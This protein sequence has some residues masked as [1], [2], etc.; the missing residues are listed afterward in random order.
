MAVPRVFISSTCYDL[1]EIRFQLRK[2]IQDIGYEPVMSEFGDI[3]Y[4]LGDHVQDACKEEINRSNIF[5]LVIGNNYGSTYHKHAGNKDIPD[6][7]TLQEFKKALEVGIPKYIFINRFVQ[8]DFENYKRTLSKHIAQYFSKNDV[9]DNQVENTKNNL[10][11]QYDTSYPFP[12]DAYKYVFYFLDIVYSLNV[13]NARYPFESFDDIK[14]VLRKQWAGFVYDALTKESTVPIEK[15]D[16]FGKKLEKIEHQLRLIAESTKVTGEHNKVTIDLEKLTSDMDI[17]NL[18]VMQNKINT[19]LIDILKDVE[20][21]P[22]I[23]F[24]Q[25]ITEKDCSVFMESLNELVKN[26]KWSKYV[27]ITEIMKDFKYVYWE[28][29]ADI[30]YKTLLEFSI[31][32]NNLSDVDKNLLKKT[33][34]IKFNEQFVPDE[35][36]SDDVPF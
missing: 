32:L 6:S 22:R 17:E 1:Q 23:E 2:F 30:P 11:K 29:R 12:Q 26:Y 19:L 14:D 8:H 16:S 36:V 21:N 24:K 25:S 5:V 10:K 33:I 15:I 31:I 3:F 28:D 20:Y 7:V 4:D 9:N 13:N 35:E 27:P 34:S 18:E